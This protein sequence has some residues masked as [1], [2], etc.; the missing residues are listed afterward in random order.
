MTAEQVILRSSGV[1]QDCPASAGGGVGLGM[2]LYTM[3]A[4]NMARLKNRET[5]YGKAYLRSFVPKAV[6]PYPPTDIALTDMEPGFLV[7]GTLC[8]ML[9][10][11]RR[12]NHAGGRGQPAGQGIL[13]LRIRGGQGGE[14][15]AVTLGWEHRRP[16]A[17]WC[18][19]GR[20]LLDPEARRGVLGAGGRAQQ[21]AGAGLWRQPGSVRSERTPKG[22]P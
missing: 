9:V 17:V 18:G 8:G 15:P 13:G 12:A 2:R 7:Q 1:K 20:G 21:R 16:Q 10:G 19:I 4:A 22:T 11:R 3:D 5:E 6:R 14:H